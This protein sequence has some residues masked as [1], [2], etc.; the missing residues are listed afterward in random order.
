MALCTKT[1]DGTNLCWGHYNKGLKKL[2]ATKDGLEPVDTKN[3]TKKTAV[4]DGFMYQTRDG[5]I[6]VGTKNDGLKKL[7]AARD[8]LEP[9]NKTIDKDKTAVADGF[10][11]QTR[12]GTIYVG[13]K[14]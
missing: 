7:N 13:T 6:Y 11:Y 12:D 10:M 2:N 3:V 1:R 14:K 9:V 5:T 8:G 4:A